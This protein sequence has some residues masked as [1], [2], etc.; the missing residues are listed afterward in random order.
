M[1]ATTYT[2]IAGFSLMLCNC[3]VGSSNDEFINN[4]A[5]LPSSLNIDH[6]GLKVISTFFNPKQKNTSLLYGNAQ[7]LANAISGQQKIIVAGQL[8]KLITWKSQSDA[9]WFGAN[10]PGELLTVEV[11]K[12]VGS[13]GQSAIIM[14]SRFKGKNMQPD[15]DTSHNQ[16]RVQ[17]ILRQKPTIIP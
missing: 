5:S 2:L 8:F 11:L 10:I 4:E 16:E 6:A 14:Y 15:S 17:F 13:E 3:S 12:T 1:K 7:A 9:N